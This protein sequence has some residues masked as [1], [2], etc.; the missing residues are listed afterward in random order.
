[1]NAAVEQFEAAFKGGDHKAFLEANLRIL[2]ALKEVGERVV[3]LKN[4]G[5]IDDHEAQVT[6]ADV[7]K[8]PRYRRGREGNDADMFVLE[9]L[10]A[11]IMLELSKANG[12]EDAIDAYIRWQTLCRQENCI[13]FE[14]DASQRFPDLATRIRRGKVD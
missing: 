4:M 11:F 2:K 12:G 6:G 8:D 14:R 10:N 13:K 9:N 7:L 3:Q 1:M 5:K